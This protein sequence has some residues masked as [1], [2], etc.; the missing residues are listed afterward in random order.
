MRS[1]FAIGSL[2]VFFVAAT[3][4]SQDALPRNYRQSD[5]GYLLRAMPPEGESIRGLSRTKLEAAATAGDP[6]ACLALARRSMESGPSGMREAM[7]WVETAANAGSADAQYV[8]G[9][10][11]SSPPTPPGTVVVGDYPRAALW[12][13]KA[14]RQNH[15]KAALELAALYIGGQLERDYAA[16]AKWLKIAAQ[17][18]DMKP[19]K[20][21]G[22]LYRWHGHPD[23]PTQPHGR[24][25]VVWYERAAKLGDSESQYLLAGLL[26]RGFGGEGRKAEAQEW[27]RKSARSGS[28]EAVIGASGLIP[29]EV[30]NGPAFPTSPDDP[31]KEPTGKIDLE[32]IPL[33]RLAAI[34]D[35][36][37]WTTRGSGFPDGQLLRGRL[38]ELRARTGQD[39]SEALDRYQ[40]AAMWGKGPT[41]ASARQG[42]FRLLTNPKFRPEHPLRG[43]LVSASGEELRD[44]AA[45]F[46]LGEVWWHGTA[47]LAANR[48]NAVSCFLNAARI[49]SPEAM[50]RLGDLWRDGAHGAAEPTEAV[51]WWMKAALLGHAEAQVRAGEA[52]R[53]GAGVQKDLPK[54][55]AWFGLAAAQ[56]RSD[57]KTAGEEI[58][59]DLSAEDRLLRDEWTRRLGRRIASQTAPEASR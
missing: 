29:L 11:A 15:T 9:Y 46:A 41:Q 56:G 40:Q 59:V 3:V 53:Q 43:D 22:D 27:M 44:A 18:G 50:V 57:A 28:L 5:I 10:D 34:E 33:N 38:L 58:G 31:W 49:G 24:E 19:F 39:F 20:Q 42:A 16:A 36:L 35:A 26:A 1:C 47:A 2:L 4:S 30:F 14:A 45:R 12:W 52:I 54:A 25:A 23:D 17:S 55:A 8:L 21:L 32:S 6:E 7:R 13:E 37:T 48:T 51:R